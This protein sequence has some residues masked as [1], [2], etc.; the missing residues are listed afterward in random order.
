MEEKLDYLTQM[1]VK[2]L[3][4]G[5]IHTVQADQLDA[6][7]LVSV[8]SAVG[9]ENDLNSLLDQA[10]KKG[11]LWPWM[12]FNPARST[13]LKIKVFHDAIEEPLFVYMVP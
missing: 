10:N 5:P 4:L 12:A 9:T 7:D 6:L 13:L 2:G 3:I 11:D 8:K 1:K